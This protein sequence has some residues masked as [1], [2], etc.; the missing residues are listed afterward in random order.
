MEVVFLA[1]NS[2]FLNLQLL[3]Y[4]VYQWR[5]MNS[6]ISKN[7]NLQVLYV[8][9]SSFFFPVPKLITIIHVSAYLTSENYKGK[10]I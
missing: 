2:I 9:K 8:M 3:L 10:N 1:Q 4:F 5:Y 6:C 7:C